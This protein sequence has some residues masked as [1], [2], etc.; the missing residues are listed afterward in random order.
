[1]QDIGVGIG[2]FSS[3]T[4]K[5]TTLVDRS[6]IQTGGQ[7]AGG[8]AVPHDRNPTLRLFGLGALC[9]RTLSH[10]N[11]QTVTQTD[12]ANNGVTRQGATARCQLYSL[13]FVTVNQNR[14]RSVG[15]NFV[16]LGRSGFQQGVF[17]SKAA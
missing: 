2:N 9:H 3:Q 8:I 7:V 5:N 11:N 16:K 15:V 6:D 12:A 17:W 13:T 4:A 1:M 10:M 14:C